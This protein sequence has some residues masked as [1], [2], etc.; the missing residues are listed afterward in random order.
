MVKSAVVLRPIVPDDGEALVQLA[1]SSPDTG[2]IQVS[3]VYHVDPYQIALAEN[4]ETVG[5]VAHCS[6]GQSIR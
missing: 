4:P 5:I 2:Q 6:I 3:A 1:L